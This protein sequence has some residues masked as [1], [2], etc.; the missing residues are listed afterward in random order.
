MNAIDLIKLSVVIWHAFSNKCD[1]FALFFFHSHTFEI[2]QAN[3]IHSAAYV[4]AISVL[5]TNK[6][7]C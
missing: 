5:Y 6:P 4:I 1:G 3:E 2:L 7:A